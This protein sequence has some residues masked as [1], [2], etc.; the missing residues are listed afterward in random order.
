MLFYKWI[1]LLWIRAI[2]LY[3]KNLKSDQGLWS[4]LKFFVP[5]YRYMCWRDSSVRG[6]ICNRY[7]ETFGRR[8]RG[9]RWSAKIRASHSCQDSQQSCWYDCSFVRIYHGPSILRPPMGW[10]KCGL[11]FQVVLKWRFISTQNLTLGKNYVV[12]NYS[13]RDV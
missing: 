4:D 9:R 10:L 2:T 13:I 6:S 11:L 12:L 3:V 1:S 5:C 8:N 7:S